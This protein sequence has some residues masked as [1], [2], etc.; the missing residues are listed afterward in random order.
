MFSGL[1]ALSIMGNTLAISKL[2]RKRMRKKRTTTLFL[3]LAM[4][5]CLVT[6]FPMAG[7]DNKKMNALL[8]F[9]TCQKLFNKPS[10]NTRPDDLGSPRQTL[11]WRCHLLQA[12][13]GKHIF[14]LS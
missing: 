9:P 3:N 7:M 6:I 14:S 10:F 11:V 1:V 5:D 4:A 8:I 2:L 13:Q 12:I